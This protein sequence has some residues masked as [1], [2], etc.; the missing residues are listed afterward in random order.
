MTVDWDLTF[1]MLQV[2]GYILDLY[3]NILVNQNAMKEN[4]HET[5]QTEINTINRYKFKYTCK[6]YCALQQ[7]IFCNIL[8]ETALSQHYTVCL[9]SLDYNMN[10]SQKLAPD[11][12]HDV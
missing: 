6:Q 11:K 7:S 10:V 1:K 8:K 12:T 5:M 2:Y 4:F 3:D 9:H